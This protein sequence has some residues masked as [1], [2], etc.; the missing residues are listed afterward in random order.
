MMIEIATVMKYE[1]GIAQVQ[2]MAKTACGGCAAKNHCGTKA[3]SALAGEK[4][5]PQFSLAVDEP[6]AVGDRIQLG[7]AETTLLTGVLW[8]YGLPLLTLVLSA[9]GFSALFANELWVAI[10]VLISTACAFGI[11][12]K[13]MNKKQQQELTPLFLGKVS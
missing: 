3:L 11:V 12:K 1:N 9:I 7:L 13:I 6:L 5:A 10:G 2:C 8:L 4:T